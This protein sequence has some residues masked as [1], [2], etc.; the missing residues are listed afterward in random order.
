[1][2]LNAINNSL[3]AILEQYGRS[4]ASK[5]FEEQLAEIDDLMLVF[6]LTQA[7]KAQ[8][9]QY[10]GRELGLCWQR[11]VT[12]LYQQTHPDFSRAIRAGGDELCDFVAGGE[13]I[14]TQYRI[15]SGDSGT[16]KKFRHYGL[17]LREL[18]FRPVLLVLRNDN[19]PA[20][21]TA[22]MKGGWAVMTGLET[23]SHIL[24]STGLDLQGWLQSREGQFT[25]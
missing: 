22:C 5:Q 10:W 25:P 3:E 13:A 4:F 14:D 15:G 12:S 6:G 9:R 7:T 24:N 8:H 20:A 18:G 19:L 17:R 16:L 11:L 2:N 1:M 21:I 23:Y